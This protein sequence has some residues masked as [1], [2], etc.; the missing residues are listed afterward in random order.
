MFPG[1]TDF[2]V[3]VSPTISIHGIKSAP[4]PPTARPLLLLHGFPQTHHIW[5]LVAPQLTSQ[6]IIIALDLRGYGTSSKPPGS[7][8]HTE[9]AK[10]TMAQ[11]CVIVMKTLGFETFYICAHDRGARVAHKLCVDFPA[12]VTKAI[13]LDIAPTLAMYSQTDFTFA[14]AYFHWFLLIQAP[15]LPEQCILHD[16]EA[17]ARQFMGGRYA[18]IEMFDPRA[19]AEYLKGLGQ[20][21]AVHAMCEDYRAGATVDLEEAREDIKEGRHVRCPLRVLW[22]QHGVIE[23]CFDAMKEWKLVHETGEVSGES[24]DCGHYIPEEKPDVVV[25]HIQEFFS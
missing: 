8:T 6:F 16:P 23:K 15:P 10:S 3:P 13:F 21:E 12:L 1:F 22:G 25:R 9:Y 2:T 4:S 20:A 7:S 17:F 19:L 18:G 5:H 24:V 14:R 11:D